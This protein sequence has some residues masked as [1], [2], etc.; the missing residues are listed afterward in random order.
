MD[1]KRGWFATPFKRLSAF[2]QI[3]LQLGLIYSCLNLTI[4]FR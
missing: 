3:N 4:V 1:L 2:W